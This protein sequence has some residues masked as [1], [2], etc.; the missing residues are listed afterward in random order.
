MNTGAR[1][2]GLRPDS[3]PPMDLTCIRC[4]QTYPLDYLRLRCA[5][6]GALEIAG[7]PFLDP[8]Q[9]DERD[10]TLWRYRHTFPLPPEVPPVSLGEGMTPLVEARWSDRAILLKCEFLNP[11]GSFKD[12]GTTVLVTALK[13]AG[14]EHVVEDSSG[15]AGAS[16]AA[17]AARAGI[18]ASV[19]VPA[20]ASGPKREQIAAHGAEVV[21]VPGPR[22]AAARAV[23]EAVEAGAVYASHVYHPLILSGMKTAAYEIWEQLGGRA[24][25]AVVLPLGHGSLLLGLAR[26]FE[27]LRITG[28]IHT[29]PRLFGAQAAACAP[30]AAAWEQGAEEP[31]PAT[32]RETIAE[33]V[34]IA[35]PVRGRAV[36]AAVRASGGGILALS[37]AEIRAARDR[38]ARMG[39]YVEPTAALAAAA[40][41]HLPNLDGTVV[42]VLTGHGLKAPA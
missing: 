41:D 5:C 38:L 24:P 33:G 30:L 1:N 31:L 21:P 8:A 15:N 17:Y 7:T 42:V 4:L 19:Y 2:P 39:F 36:L 26:G 6:G 10:L 14:V 20:H 11:T 25:D 32:E 22:T 37:E 12:R 28:L 29:A 3:V 40:L 35:A 27:E 16:L 9:I 34:R 13:E 23:L 18:R